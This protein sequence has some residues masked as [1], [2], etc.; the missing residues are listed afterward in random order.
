MSILDKVKRHISDNRG[1]YG[2][3][4]G[5]GGTIGVD[6]AS[7]E[8]PSTP[9]V[10]NKAM[11]NAMAKGQN[12]ALDAADKI[13]YGKQQ[14]QNMGLE[15]KISP[16]DIQAGNDVYNSGL[17]KLINPS[18]TDMVNAT[19]RNSKFGSEVED[20]KNQYNQFSDN[21]D[22]AALG[23]VNQGVNYIK[24]LNPF[25]ESTNI[26]GNAMKIEIKNLLLEGYSPEVIVEAVHA[27][28]PQLD[29]RNPENAGRR[30]EF[31]KDIRGIRAAR[32]DLR[33][34]KR[35]PNGSK[36]FRANIDTTGSSDN[37]QARA[38]HYDNEAR[39]YSQQGTQTSIGNTNEFS[40]LKTGEFSMAKHNAP[41]IAGQ[42]HPR[43]VSS[44]KQ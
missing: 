23:Y 18:P 3:G 39:S 7:N 40:G 30:S 35:Y 20:L 12:L 1:K 42:S 21:L 34:D 8:L 44:A 16:E 32:D 22:N 17:G 43:V 14:L 5:V 41:Y 36:D 31:A 24:G 13:G 26:Q 38:N 6:Y 9:V 15:N 28:H 19:E 33:V 37:R 4:A 25:H 10:I 2:I 27:N 29:K 11:F